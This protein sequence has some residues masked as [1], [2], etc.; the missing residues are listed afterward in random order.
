MADRIQLSSSTVVSSSSYL[1]PVLHALWQRHLAGQ[2]AMLS[3]Y[4][5]TIYFLSD[6]SLVFPC[7]LLL[8]QE[9]LAHLHKT[10]NVSQC[11]Q[12]SVTSESA[13]ESPHQHPVPPAFA[14]HPTAGQLILS[15]CPDTSSSA[16]THQFSQEKFEK[17]I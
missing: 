5:Y 9:S 14:S 2:L 10:A 11:G 16:V 6:C 1:L 8:P 4:K 12:H 13:A 7:W 17:I 15:L 3:S